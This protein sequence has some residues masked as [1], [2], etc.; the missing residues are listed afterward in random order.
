MPSSG[1]KSRS[2]LLSLQLAAM[3][4]AALVVLK[5]GHRTVAC[6]AEAE[7]TDGAGGS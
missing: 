4:A 1:T 5:Q 3:N 2:L 7:V 6:P